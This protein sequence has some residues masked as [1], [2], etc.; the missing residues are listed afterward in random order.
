[1]AKQDNT[2]NA[3]VDVILPDKFDDQLKST[4]EIITKVTKGAAEIRVLKGEIKT[5][6]TDLIKMYTNYVGRYGEDDEAMDVSI[7]QELILTLP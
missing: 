1:M 4:K 6:V 5:I 3:R 2:N 7:D